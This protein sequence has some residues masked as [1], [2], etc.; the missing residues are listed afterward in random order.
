MITFTEINLENHYLANAA[1]AD[2]LLYL[3]QKMIE[4]KEGSFLS[5]EG[6]RILFDRNELLTDVALVQLVSTSLVDDVLDRAQR[7][8]SN[9]SAPDLWVTLQLA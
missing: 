3:K 2:V 7:L 4:R 1:P 9:P 5:D 8:E 6:Q